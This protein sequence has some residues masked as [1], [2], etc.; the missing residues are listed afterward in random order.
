MMPPRQ[1]AILVGGLGS[2][3]GALTRE[4][5]KPLLD[6]GGRPFLSWIIRELSRFGIEEIVLLAGYRSQQITDFTEQVIATLPKKVRIS[7]SIE[8]HQAGTGGAIFHAR[9]QLH[10]RFML[11]NG[12][13]WFDV[14]LA[15]FFTAAARTPNT[16][17]HLLLRHVADS[18]RYGTVELN[19]GRVSEFKERSSV[20]TSAMVNAGIYVLSKD[21][22][23]FMSAQC[24]IERDVF[25][26]L[27]E[28]GLLSGQAMHG[29][30][31]DIGIPEDYARAATE[32][33][34]HLIRPAVF[35]DRDGVLNEDKG[36]VGDRERF[37]WLEGS[38]HAV[39]LVND[40]GYHAFVV[41]NQAGV[42][43]GFYAE[44][45]V[46]ALHTWMRGE[47]LE[48]GAMI[49]DI[50]YC[51]HHVDA[52]TEQYRRDCSM[53]KPKPGMVNAL[54][55]RWSVDRSGSFLIG[56]KESDLAAAAAAGISGRLYQSGDLSSLI[57]AELLEKRPAID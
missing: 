42:A 2:R 19:N 26:Q 16:L 55:E 18:S 37:V 27:A 22:L 24:S 44:A 50:K 9:D 10:D 52:V 45:D 8:P 20:Q 32:I 25:P 36:W 11:V 39:G 23:S 47:L 15:R 40:A 1:C 56:D 13:S 35:F 51:P 7:I 29:Y 46:E 49:D 41:T 12:D 17:G 21:I 54:C 57:S 4:V 3:L 43:K 6:C 5:P 30:F 53:R 34:R 28:R 14:N 33:P 48:A 31:I 38:K